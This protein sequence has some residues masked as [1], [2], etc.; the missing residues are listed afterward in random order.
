MFDWITKPYIQW[1]FIDRIISLAEVI[2]LF[3]VITIIAYTIVDII[4]KL[5]EKKD[6]KNGIKR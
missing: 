5:R 3:V 2:I 1:N 6:K 4:E